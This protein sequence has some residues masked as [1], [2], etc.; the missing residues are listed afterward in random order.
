MGGG[1]LGSEWMG[2]GGNGEVGEQG[3]DVEM[4]KG[5]NVVEGGAHS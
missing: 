3:A 4:R 2:E 5:G 1:G